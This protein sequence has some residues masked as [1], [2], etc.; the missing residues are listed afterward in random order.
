[1]AALVILLGFVAISRRL[2][3]G[4]AYV[5]VASVGLILFTAACALTTRS[6]I[7]ALP[8]LILLLSNLAPI[9]LGE[10]APSNLV[11]VVMMVGAG[12]LEGLF[13][14]RFASW[15][16]ESGRRKSL[17]FQT[18]PRWAWALPGI[19][20]ASAV[21]AAVLNGNA[22]VP[23]ERAVRSSASV[24]TV[25]S[26][27]DFN[28]IQLDTTGRYLFASGHGLN[29]IRRY[30][31]ADWSSP[32]VELDVATNRAQGFTYDTARGELYVHDVPN[33]RLLCIDD[34][35]LKL[36]RT[37]DVKGLSPGDAWIVLDPKTDTISISSEADEE[38]GTPF[39]LLER[40]S[41]RVLGTLDVEA[42]SLLLDPKKSID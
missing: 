27:D 37:I 6:P 23:I 16:L 30:D 34:Q 10:R 24:R 33:E 9:D 32:P 17:N 29:H 42:G 13:F 40:S 36:K 5:L 39:M 20:L 38:T 26:N 22:L 31:T 7:F 28:W 11:R 2:S 8:A 14:W 18:M 4:K 3:L 15:V 41:G 1:M 21:S 35:S 19:V 12:I 25:V